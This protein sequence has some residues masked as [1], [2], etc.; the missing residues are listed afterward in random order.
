MS[1]ATCDDAIRMVADELPLHL[2]ALVE[3]LDDEILHRTEF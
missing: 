2:R 3:S 1:F